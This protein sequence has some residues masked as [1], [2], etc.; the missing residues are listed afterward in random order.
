MI[1]IHKIFLCFAPFPV[2]SSLIRSSRNPLQHYDILL[3]LPSRDLRR[4]ALPPPPP[5]SAMESDHI[6]G[7]YPRG[8]ETLQGGRQHH[9][10]NPM[11]QLWLLCRKFFPLSPGPLSLISFMP[12]RMQDF[13]LSPVLSPT[14]IA[15]GALLVWNAAEQCFCPKCIGGLVD[16]FFCT[17]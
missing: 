15:A 4:S 10:P 14:G 16:P 8:L 3:E 7:H 1:G 13:I 9:L 5:G 12:S 11:A 6:T 17:S 2:N